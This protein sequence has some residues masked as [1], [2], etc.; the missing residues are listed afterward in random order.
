MDKSSP[1]KLPFKL[2]RRFC[3]PDYLIDIEGDLRELHE[4]REK[5]HGVKKAKLLLYKDVLML[6]R[7]GIIR[8]LY[9]TNNPLIHPTMV[10]HNLLI[11]YRGFLRNKSSFL[12]NVIGLS[13]GLACVFVIYLWVKNE[14][15]MDKFHEKDSQLYQVMNN[16]NGTEGI[17]TSQKTTMPLA[18]AL[19]E[20]FPEVEHAVFTTK[21]FSK[22]TILFQDKSIG[23]ERLMASEQFFD[24]FSYK[25]LIGNKEQVLSDK[26]KLLL[27]ET[28]ARKIFS[29]PQKAIGKVVEWKHP[30][31]EQF[32]RTFTVSGIFSAPP[33]HSTEQFDAITHSDLQ[34]EL[35]PYSEEWN[36]ISGSTVLV[37]KKGTDTEN[38]NTKI[39]HLLEK[40]D[41]STYENSLFVQKYAQKYLYGHYENG[42]PAGGRIE[43]IKYFSLLALFILAIACIN[44]INLTTAQTSKKMKELG[45]KKTI[46]ASR[47]T[48]V[49]QFLSE[50]L[51]L[52]FIA[53]I[54][55]VAMSVFVLPH[56]NS[57]IGTNIPLAF[58]PTIILF[59][60]GIV[61][62]TGLLAGA[63]PAFYLSS[64]K[65][66]QVLKG[67]LAVPLNE[68][69]IR[70]GLVV[71]QFAISVIFILGVI[72]LG[73]QLEY[74][75]AKNL[76]FNRQNVVSFQ[77][78]KHDVDPETFLQAIK[79]IPGVKNASV[80]FG[81]ILSGRDDQMGYS[82][83]GSDTDR[84]FI[85]KAPRIGYDLVETLDMKMLAGRSFSKEFQ[86]ESEKIIL[87]EAAIEMMQLENPIGKEIAHAS[88][89]KEIIGVVENFH[90]GSLH[91]PIEP[92][93]FRYSNRGWGTN[94]LV[95][96]QGGMEKASLSQIEKL[97]QAFYPD[98]SFMY[99]FLDKDYQNLYK[100]ESRTAI[101]SKYL[102]GMA[103]LISCLGL[104]G[105][106]TFTTERRKKEIGIRRVLGASAL[107]IVDLLS[108]DFTYL[109]LMAI[110]IGFPVSYLL[111]K[112]W[113]NHFAYKIDISIWYYLFTAIGI[114]ILVW[115]TLGLQTF[116]AA[117]TNL[118]EN[119]KDE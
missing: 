19:V 24:V 58:N 33:L 82:W 67:K 43:Y 53:S 42:K 60:G 87:N 119:L 103:I 108:R 102:G 70:K 46:G 90:Y 31:Y 62:L 28:L 117:S 110:A 50:T 45:V 4:R 21:T 7:P 17:R 54:F 55:A 97:Y 18:D 101:L 51:L 77:R 95:K 61:L 5:V 94:T 98:A 29:E 85:F 92:L 63:Y 13:T 26:N 30:H 79:G 11:A 74:T 27:S 80:M 91:N 56:F 40:Y 106:I 83:S 73:K 16:Y 107:Q 38:F 78:P 111:A 114:M 100:T 105:L 10:R 104:L 89:E 9:P 116:R 109:V 69:W 59:L 37:L 22:G 39:A 86:N 34:G 35:D 8:S 118:V 75:Q 23:A 71:F 47:K 44:F 68:Q 99:T 64:F 14:L 2:L 49:G 1:P 112:Q 76:G 32:N 15:S 65:P 57:I 25:L 96:I 113:L 81:S 52:V 41:P 3:K 72:V 84:K 6:F 48:L 66:Y 93:V 88:G 115:G 12:I 36:I 20:E